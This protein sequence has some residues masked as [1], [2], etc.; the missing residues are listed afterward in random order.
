MCL[1]QL[2]DDYFTFS[3]L[4]TTEPVQKPV[5]CVQPQN[6]QVVYG[7]TARLLIEVENP[8]YST[9]Y[10]WYRDGKALIG[11]TFPE[12]LIHSAV[13][14][15]SGHYCCK[16]TNHGGSVNSD[17]AY[18]RVIV[19]EPSGRRRLPH[20][21]VLRFMK[22]QLQGREGVEEEGEGERNVVGDLLPRGQ[23]LDTRHFY[24]VSSSEC[25][26]ILDVIGR[27]WP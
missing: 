26:Y 8:D 2:L 6:K 20:P 24:T 7:Q 18:I 11:K 5:I 3:C 23:P 1:K 27:A 12:L 13:D 10:Q 25:Q 15:D 17:S 14:S 19:I 22:S 21:D 16:V 4:Y 9:T